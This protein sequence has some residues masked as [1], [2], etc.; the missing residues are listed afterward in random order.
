ML[1]K[2]QSVTYE[3]VDNDTPSP[4]DG[5]KLSDQVCGSA[6]WSISEYTSTDTT[7]NYRFLKSTDSCVRELVAEFIEINLTYDYTT[8]IFIGKIN[9]K[10]YIVMSEYGGPSTKHIYAV[11]DSPND[12]MKIIKFSKHVE[13]AQCIIKLQRVRLLMLI[14][15]SDPAM[16]P[17]DII[18]ELSKKLT[19]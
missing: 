19:G 13:F 7:L 18:E 4:I 12:V 5:T 16:L 17:Y 11:Y 1:V 14:F 10:S 2:C 9:R 3:D 8:N 15:T 6:P